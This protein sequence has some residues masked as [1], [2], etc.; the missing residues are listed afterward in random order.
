MFYKISKLDELTQ[1]ILDMMPALQEFFESEDTI[2]EYSKK[3]NDYQSDQIYIDRQKKFIEIAK[4]K[5]NRLFNSEEKKKIKVLD[6]IEQGLK[7]GVV[8]HHGILNEPIL[9]GVN[10]VS[11]YYKLFDREKNGDI[12]TFATGNVP[13]NDAFHR[14]GFM[15]D[16]KR[17]NIFRR[18][19]KSKFV[20]Q[21]SV[22][23]INFVDS[24]KKNNQWNLYSRQT[25]N[26]LLQAQELISSIDL[27][28]CETLGDQLTKINFHLWPLIFNSETR[29]KVS[30]LISL[31]YEELA[32]DYLIYVLETDK[33][34]FIYRFLFDVETREKALIHFEGKTGAWDGKR[35][36]G[37]HFFWYYSDE[38][39]Q[40]RL[41]LEKEVL[42]SEDGSIKI[43]WTEEEIVKSLRIRKL[44][45][46]ML[47]K[48]SLLI[49]YLGIRPLTGLGSTYYISLMQQDMFK[50]LK[51]RYPE[52][53]ERMSKIKVNNMTT[54]PVVLKKTKQ[55]IEDYFAFDVMKDGGLTKEYL[56]RINQV[57]LK[58]FMATGLNVTYDYAF[59]KYGKGKK[60]EIIIKP[61]DYSSLFEGVF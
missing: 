11:D 60:K 61:E 51:E 47:L 3:L 24:L 50:F 35:N 2:E 34:S 20:F 16:G 45:P 42:V 19:D 58:N 8:D 36:R 5:I 53:A 9:L 17:V 32:I 40:V 15:I 56:H 26:F 46:G 6:N 48:Y 37:T 39:K 59:S 49:F 1:E 54:V 27:A 18:D 25:Q 28:G 7:S 44:V 4:N 29:E 31:E 23:K 55:G 41:R 12:F 33:S 57:S 10:I 21:L 52:E 38:N 13:L 43:D 30:N 22:Q 14:R